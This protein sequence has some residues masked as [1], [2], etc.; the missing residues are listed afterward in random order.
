MKEAYTRCLKMLR[1]FR[2]SLN[3]EKDSKRGTLYFSW[4]KDKTEKIVNE[5]DGD[6]I[7][8]NIVQYTLKNYQ[9]DKYN[10]ERL[11]KELK[12]I[13]ECILLSY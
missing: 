10:Y 5:K 13:E 6:Y 8:K 7:Y 1:E 4:I 12:N 3:G 2:K 11:N 9:I